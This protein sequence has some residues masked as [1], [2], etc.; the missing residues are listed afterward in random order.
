[1][2]ASEVGGV[3]SGG[4]A[5][6][7]AA[8]CD[9]AAEAA[10]ANGAAPSPAAGMNGVAVSDAM[11][12]QLRLPTGPMAPF[13]AVLLNHRNQALIQRCIQALDVRTGDWVLD[14]GFGGAVSLAV[15]LRRVAGA[16][17]HVCG[18]D[19]SPD[20]VCRASRLLAA[21]VAA[22]RL[23]LEVAGVEA[24]PCADAS[25]DHV[26]TVQTVYFWSDLRGGVG[27]VARVLRAG[28]RLAIGMMAR[29]AQE[30]HDFH[31]RGYH[32]VGADDLAT[33]LAGA[34]FDEIG[35]SAGTDD[36]SVVVVARRP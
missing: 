36:G 18:I 27:E 8:G 23:W 21:D 24:I 26:L 13:T 1:M 4:G 7:L 34:G 12:D 33:L 31:R 14:V 16:G 2:E 28:G 22:G 9:G 15:L 25:L 30:E 35:S 6:A 11:A 29:D 19:P 17:G 10:A 5:P 32:V 3:V 20:M